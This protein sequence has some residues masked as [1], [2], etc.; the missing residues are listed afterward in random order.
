ML[1]SLRLV[2]VCVCICPFRSYC[3][4]RAIILSDSLYEVVHPENIKCDDF[5]FF[6]ENSKLAPFWQK[7]PKFAHF[8]LFLPKHYYNFAVETKFMVFF[9]KIIML[10][11]GK[12]WNDQNLALF[13]QNFVFF[14]PKFAISAFNLK[15]YYT[16]SYSFLYKLNLWSSAVNKIYWCWSKFVPL[17]LLI[18]YKLQ[19]IFFT[20]K[21][22]Y[23]C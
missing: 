18:H 17:D 23:V 15:R 22:R 3:Q 9:W 16:F 13:A 4:N 1:N 6:G 20:P 19:T 11:L 5:R 7:G 21:I 12:F 10:M 2:F 14:G 8:A